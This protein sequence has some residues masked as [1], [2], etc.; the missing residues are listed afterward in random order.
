MDNSLI[1]GFFDGVHIAHQAVISSAK[2]YPVLITFKDSPAK[3][4]NRKC[5]YILSREESVKKIKS[6][7]VKE[8]VELDF[9][10]FA[11][12]PAKDYLEFLIRKYNPVS[13]ST[14]FNHTFGFN[15]SGNT[16]FLE[17]NQT[18]YGYKYYCIEPQKDNG[19]IISSTLIRNLLSDGNI[20]R[21][22]K[23]LNS[24]FILEG[25]VIQGAQLG[26]KLGFP[27]ANI[28]YPE[29]IVKIP[30]GVYKAKC[31]G[32]AAILNWGIK[33][34][35]NNT[36]VP[37]IEVHLLNFSGDLYGQK[38]KIEVLKKIRDEKKFN[39]IDELKTQIE[40]DIEE[41]LK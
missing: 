26:R 36:P 41:C 13:I 30:F 10:E 12:M 29:E 34:T 5:E 6:L 23:L 2:N 19:E 20:E 28:M 38:L 32:H 37:I 9:A 25:T 21:A 16:D 7:G 33:P 40:K 15:K 3:F 8:V 14:G 18:K 1:L 17:Q 4:F 22:N 24:N 31:N 27:T 11:A 39:S 35:V